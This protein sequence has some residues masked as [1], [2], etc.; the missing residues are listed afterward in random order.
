MVTITISK[1]GPA[2]LALQSGVVQFVE[3]GPVGCLDGHDIPVIVETRKRLAGEMTKTFCVAGVIPVVVRRVRQ[4]HCGRGGTRQVLERTPTGPFLV[5]AT[6]T[7]RY[8]FL[9]Y[10]S[11]ALGSRGVYTV[12]L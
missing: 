1:R 11:A 2:Y 12:H 10:P 9:V 3:C 5:V 6:T 8:T 4:Q 7:K